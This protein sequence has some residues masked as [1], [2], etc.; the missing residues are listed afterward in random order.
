MPDMQFPALVDLTSEHIAY[1]A[2][3]AG[4]PEWLIE[5]RTQ[6]WD[7]FTQAIPPVWRRTDLTAIQPETITPAADHQ[8]TALQWDESLASQGVVFTT[9]SAALQSHEQIIR[10]KMGTAIPPHTHK[11]SALR[12]ALWK[13]GVFLYV[14]RNVT[15]DIPL[16]VCYMLA[17]DG[18]SRFPYTLVVL[19]PGARVTLIEEF[20]SRNSSS[21]NGNGS[22]GIL[23]AGTTAEHF[24]GDNSEMR[25]ASIQQWGDNVYHIGGQVQLFGAHARSE[26]VSIALGGKTQHIEADARMNGDGSVVTWRGATFADDHQLLLTA[27]SLTHT[28]AHTESHLDFRT[29]VTDNGYSVFDGMINILKGSRETTTRLEEH[30]IHL[31]PK[32]RSDSIPGLKIDTNDVASAGH[33][34]TSGQVDEEQLFYMQARGISKMEAIR[35]IVMGVF[36]PV[37]QAIPVEELRETL[38]VAIEEKI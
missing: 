11:F 2:R 26:W 20:T 35:M 34:C 7:Y 28:G 33:A 38:H 5:Q 32:S 6:A 14:P 29:V 18:L 4:E 15:V 37:F 3:T 24:L 21:D 10:E 30:A 1:V 8:Q 19:E 16:R 27:P 23:L 36:D 12:A 25:Y 13:D 22:G 17:E 31:S 9:L